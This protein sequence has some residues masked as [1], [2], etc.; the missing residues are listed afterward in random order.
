MTGSGG[1]SG[2][3]VSADFSGACEQAENII[4]AIDAAESTEFDTS[5]EALIALSKA[6]VSKNVIARMQK[7]R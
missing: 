4:M 1:G 2:A 5:P 6:G 3:F 7:R